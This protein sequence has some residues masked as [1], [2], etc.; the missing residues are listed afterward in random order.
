MTFVLAAWLVLQDADPKAAIAEFG[1]KFKK[2][3]THDEKITA[4]QQLNV[5]PHPQILKELVK[6]LKESDPAV[7]KAVIFEI[8]R[9]RKSKA[10]GEALNKQLSVEAAAAKLDSAQ[11]YAG[12]EMFMVVGQ[13]IGG[14]AYRGS[15]PALI[16][17]FTHANLELGKTAMRVAGELK[18]LEAIEPLIG[19]LR[20]W[21][22]ASVEDPYAKG[23]PGGGGDPGNFVKHGT[24][25]KKGGAN[26]SAEDLVKVDKYNRKNQ[27]PSTAINALVAITEQNLR[28]PAD[29]EKW[30]SSNKARIQ[31]EIKDQSKAGD[32]EEKE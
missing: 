29:W 1:P 24:G 30:W 20:E 8:A 12:H 32:P 31:K 25:S 11:V 9:Y 18:C 15:G 14:V 22:N 10:A 4:L 23:N 2:A 5:K 7:R 27:I 21:S 16:P 6:L 17:Y 3:K 26:F 19:L 13:A 28:G